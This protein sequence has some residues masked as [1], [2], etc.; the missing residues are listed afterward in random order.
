MRFAL[1]KDMRV[2]TTPN[3]KAICPGCT[4]QVVAKCGSKRIH[5]WAHQSNKN[6][7][8]WWEAETE[9]HRNWKKEFPLNW[10]EI[11]MRDE[12]TGELHIADVRTDNNI[13]IEFQHSHIDTK[14][15][16]SRESFYTNLI[17]VVDGT[18]LKNDFKRFQ[19]GKYYFS[20]LMPQVFRTSFSYEIFPS[21]WIYRPVA[22][23]FDF[24]RIETPKKSRHTK[25]YCL[26]PQRLNNEF[27]VAE[28]S[29]EAFIVSITKGN[30]L[31][32]FENFINKIKAI[33]IA[34]RETF[35]ALELI[36]SRNNR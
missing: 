18:R 4:Q 29:R 14:E 7:D 12:I 16:A 21:N 3:G 23:I 2:E 24:G 8:K 22:V 15:Q 27:I 34:E 11:I 31:Q 32:R 28:I 9:W 26:F 36:A 19:K 25:L 5:H 20:S 1:I 6:C 13:I 35:A 30:W 33:E 17:W 10:Q